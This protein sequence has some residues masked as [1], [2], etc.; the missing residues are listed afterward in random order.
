M[1]VLHTMQV[2]VDVPE[3]AGSLV[4]EI[5]R[6]GVLATVGEAAAVPIADIKID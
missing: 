6:P 3:I 4:L 5:V 1:L 2:V